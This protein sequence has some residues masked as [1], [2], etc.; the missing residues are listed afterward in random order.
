MYVFAYVV[1][2]SLTCLAAANPTT[3]PAA[4]AQV[5]V[6]EQIESFLDN[7]HYLSNE[8]IGDLFTRLNKDY[9]TLAQ[10]YV[11][12]TT[13]E[14]R[15]MNALALNA[16]TS[17]ATTGDLLRPMVKLVANV[18][19]DET[20]GRQIVLYMA[21]YL[22][23]SYEI[24]KEVQRLLNTT[25]IHF[26]PS[27]N[28]DGFALAKEGNCESL[29]NYVGRGNAVGVDLNRDFPD[30][31][32]QQHVNHLRSQSRQPETAALAEWIVS[33]PFVL[34]AN[35]HGGAVVASYPYDNSLA[36]NDCCEESLTPDDRVFKQMAHTYSDNHPI[37]R[38]GNNCNDTFAGGITNG[39]NW[40]ELSGGMQDFNYAF[41]NCFELTIELS[42]CKF[43]AASTLPTEWA[44]NKRPLIELLKQA[45]IG[46]KGLVQD[47]S[48]YPI[49]DATIVVSGLEDK[50]IRTSKRGEY[51]RL[52]T[53]GIYSVY[54]AAFGYQSSAPQELH[55]TNDNAEAMRVDFK[56]SPVETNYD[57]NF[58]K[59]KVERAEPPEQLKQKF[60]G[61]LTP[62]PF[63]HHNYVAMESFLR[64]LTAS[65]PS[66]TRLYSIGKSVQ[67]RDLWVMEISTTP[68]T[69]VPGVPEFK[70]VA[71][72][73]GNEV[74]GKEMLLLLTKYLLERYENDE[75][76]TRL[77]NGTRMHFLY[78]MNPDG[79]EISRE[80]DRTSALGRANAHNV[81]LNRNFPDQ[82]GTDKF[83][84]VTEPE[85][86]AVMNWTL[87]L[88]FVLSANLHGGS[89]VANYPFDDNENDFNDPYSRLRDSSISGRKLNP[90][91]DNELFRH[92][93]LVYSRA[94][95]TMHLGQPCALFKNELFTDGIT[96]GAQW[97]SVTGGMQDWN[98]VRAGCM[99]LTIEM[100]C[101][102]FPEAKDLP[103]YWQDN[104]EPLLQLIEQVHHGV[105]GFVRSSIGTPIA[106]AAVGLNGGNQ[107][108]YSGTFGDY[109]K[110]TLPGRHNVTV[111]ADGFAPLRVEVEVPDAE[112]FGMRL[113]VTVMRDDP[114]HWASANDFRIIENVVNTRYHTNAEVRNRL[115]EL[116]NQNPQI[117]SFGYADNEFSR[118]FNYIKLT[119]NIGEPEEHKYKLLVM[120]SLYDTTAPLGREIMLNLVRHLIEGHKLQDSTVVQLL[121]RS[122]I[123]FLPQTEKFM[124]IFSMYNA[125]N[126]VCDPVVSDELAERILSPETEASRD[127][128]LQFLRNEHFDL[129]LTFSAGSSEL[130]YPKGDSILEKLAHS[131]QRTE[132]NYSPLQCS[133]SATRQLHRETTD[134][135][136]N[137]MYKLY[138]IPMYTLGLSCCRM[139]AHSQIASVWRTNIEK[140]KNFLGLVQTGISG[141][142]QNDKGQPLREAFVRLLEHEGI[143]NVSRNEARFQ[144]MLPK[145]LYG[146]EVSAPNHESQIIKTTVQSGQLIDLGAIKLHAFSLIRG[147]V[148]EL[149]GANGSGSSSSGMTSITGIV[150]DDGNHPIRNAKI[151]V[152]HPAGLT[153][154]RNFTNSMGEYYLR[155]VPVGAVTLKVEAPRHFEAT[156]DI[157]LPQAGQPTE[158]VVF[159]L[160]FNARVFGLPRFV[161]ILV[162]SVLIIVG[163]VICVLCAQ[164]WFYRRHR[165]KMPYYDFSLLPQK[166]K[167]QFEL[168]EDAG[169]D[170]ETELFRSPIKRG[171]TIQP[172]FDE[173]QLEH[174]LHTDDEDDENEVVMDMAPELELDVAD[175]SG[176]EI[177][178]LHNHKNRRKH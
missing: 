169:D 99:E 166:G 63:E 101:D 59:Q 114:Q 135:L 58:R 31:L 129:M 84:K 67:D 124:S 1:V 146:L 37:M 142:V 149:N 126:S 12:G 71:N 23:S 52:L 151:S 122:V 119:S 116:E 62:T 134:R 111:L 140:I 27:A 90:T 131:I 86:A 141:L 107:S 22:A 125:N 176:D 10:P 153:R 65:Y 75:R 154:L 74:V 34:S 81:D 25:E 55:V 160:K 8:E 11:V 98:Y 97:Y 102:K 161:F 76:V 163:V 38:R 173:E 61:F 21:E 41:S 89:L 80:G 92:L 43:P 9:P 19:G 51:W 5:Q 170:G 54:A 29:P 117:A 72:M 88:P 158:N 113:D 57:G 121:E 100:G 139:P 110:L 118:H 50:P 130:S 20:L 7:P 147:E 60:D 87:S 30:R 6:I 83:N 39:A 172:Y 44:R 178:M 128:L 18:Q 106:G 36:H 3:T 165:G 45:H 167:E 66:L 13:I 24:D 120:S 105:H 94:H 171:M 46:I 137:L 68:G 164:F 144:L 70:Y 73:H 33:K 148:T 93:A 26:L 53:P 42:C 175:E 49:A 108:T 96:N 82:Y 138:K 79:Y 40:Y 152:I 112:P 104:R 177:V 132:F 32:D 64:N 150:L 143:Y 145:G 15:P 16:P 174:I 2:V 47:A 156:R 91:E 69:H 127:L 123:Y 17:D 78:S 4:I 35:F 109:W 28:P 115:A 77:V 162:A 48:G 103:Q 159:H 14:G 56:L 133:S 136:T 157:R 155:S 95:P 168:D 85:V